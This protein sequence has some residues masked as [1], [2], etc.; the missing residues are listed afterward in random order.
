L[1]FNALPSVKKSVLLG[2]ADS[3]G[4]DVKSLIHK[5]G[6]KVG[7]LH[8]WMNSNKAIFEARWQNFEEVENMLSTYYHNLEEIAR[9]FEYYNITKSPQKEIYKKVW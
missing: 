5:L 9:Q 4:D 6:K 3:I 8:A 7:E 2:I 1:V